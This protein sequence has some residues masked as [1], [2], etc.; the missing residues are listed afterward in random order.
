MS[1]SPCEYIRGGVHRGV[2]QNVDYSF[3]TNSVYIYN[4]NFEENLHLQRIVKIYN[5]QPKITKI[6][7]EKNIYKLSIYG[8]KGGFGVLK[9][10]FYQ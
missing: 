9:N 5:L 3:F 8:T 7:I 4:P 2:Q 6:Y 1:L 10:N